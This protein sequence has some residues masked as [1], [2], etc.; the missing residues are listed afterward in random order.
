MCESGFHQ[1]LAVAFSGPSSPSMLEM[2]SSLPPVDVSFSRKRKLLAP[3]SRYWSGADCTFLTSTSG[4][5]GVPFKIFLDN[6]SMSISRAM[7]LLRATYSGWEIGEKYMQTGMT[8]DRGVVKKLKDKLLRVKY[9]SAFNLTDRQL[10][11]YLDTL[12]AEKCRYIMGYAS[13]LYLLAE[14]AEK[15]GFNTPVK[16]IVSWGDNMYPH[17]R[18]LIEK[19]FGCRVTDTYG[20]GEGIQVS[21]QCGRSSGSYHVFMPHVAVEYVDTDLNP[22]IDN[23]GEILLTRLNPGVIPLIRYR[24]GDIGSRDSA[25]ACPCGRGLELMKSIDGRA[26]DIIITP[27]GNRLIVHFFTG[28]FE[29]ARHI[30]T[31]QVVQTETSGITVKIVPKNEFN[32]QEWETLKMEILEKGDADLEINLEIVEGIPLEKSNKR[33]FVISRL[34]A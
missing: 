21:A 5:T 28:I 17:Y 32:Q 24:V 34:P 9:V 18:K 20:C 27:N 23:T 16:G 11:L 2:P 22:A 30:E 13:S 26:S 3:S 1:A 15:T 31:F 25:P 10:D 12:E 29:Y 33:R 6:H 4:S 19:Q 14:R 8:L 7:M